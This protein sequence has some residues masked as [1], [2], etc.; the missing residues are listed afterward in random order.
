M[1][2]QMENNNKI[3]MLFIILGIVSN[4]TILQA[5]SDITPTNVVSSRTTGEHTGSKYLKIFGDFNG[6]GK[7]DSAYFI[8]QEDFIDQGDRYELI[9]AFGSGD[10][11]VLSRLS[12]V[13]NLGLR[14]KNPGAFAH[15]CT[16]GHGRGCLENDSKNYINLTT[17]SIELFQYESSSRIYFWDKTRFKVMPISD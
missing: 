3:R 15:I 12:D 10:K 6:D 5:C 17:D 8:E 11:I 14:V 2:S 1:K 4:F 7:I 13:T 16:R 9:A